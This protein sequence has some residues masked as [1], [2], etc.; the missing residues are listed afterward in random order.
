MYNWMHFLLAINSDCQTRLLNVFEQI[1]MFWEIKKKKGVV[2]TCVVAACQ[3]VHWSKMQ[4]IS[5]LFLFLL[6]YTLSA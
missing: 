4:F 2:L 6:H 1:A 5:F 3:V